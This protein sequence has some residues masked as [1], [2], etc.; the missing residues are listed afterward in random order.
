MFFT[1]PTAG[2]FP[3]ISC[4][5]FIIPT[6]YASPIIFENLDAQIISNFL[7]SNFLVL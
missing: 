6:L 4:L 1:N 7:I 3:T 2:I 5:T